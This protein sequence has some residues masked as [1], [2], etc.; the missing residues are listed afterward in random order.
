MLRGSEMLNILLKSAS[1]Q[2]ERQETETIFKETGHCSRVLCCLCQP[3]S[4]GQS[5]DCTR[6]IIESLCAH[7]VSLK[8]SGMAIQNK[9]ISYRGLR[10]NDWR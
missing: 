5:P 2:F 10:A 8:Y 7:G 6:D 1:E 3:F 4:P 9:N